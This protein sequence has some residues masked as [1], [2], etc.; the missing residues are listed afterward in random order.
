MSG[1]LV[2]SFLIHLPFFLEL[3]QAYLVCHGRERSQGTQ[4]ERFRSIL[5]LVSINQMC[6][7]CTFISLLKSFQTVLREFWPKQSHFHP[8]ERRS[9]VFTCK[10]TIPFSEVYLSYLRLPCFLWEVWEKMREQSK[11]RLHTNIVI[12]K[13]VQQCDNVPP[14]TWHLE[15]EIER[16]W[17]ANERK[18]SCLGPRNLARF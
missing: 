2:K 16:T 7:F 4:W 18:L 17:K 12:R 10:R 14:L 1:Y 6:Y 3:S 11:E 15:K 9:I 5:L 8:F 13:T